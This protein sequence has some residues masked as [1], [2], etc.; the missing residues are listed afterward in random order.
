MVVER[1]VLSAG[2]VSVTTREAL[3]T[4]ARM[5]RAAQVP[6]GYASIARCLIITELVSPSGE[7]N[8]SVWEELGLT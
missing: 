6:D 7:I 3:E 5:I 1:R 2:V 8:E 4:F